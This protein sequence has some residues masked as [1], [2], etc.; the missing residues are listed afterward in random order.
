M[1][2][3]VQV[4]GEVSHASAMAVDAMGLQVPTAGVGGRPGELQLRAL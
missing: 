4:A 1:V 3:L 2:T